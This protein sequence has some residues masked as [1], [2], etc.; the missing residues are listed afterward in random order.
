MPHFTLQRVGLN[1]YL[2]G[3][4]CYRISSPDSTI[5]RKNTPKLFRAS[6]EMNSAPCASPPCRQEY[7][8][9]HDFLDYYP[10]FGNWLG[11]PVNSAYRKD[12]LIA[13]GGFDTCLPAVADY[14]KEAL[15]ALDGG[16]LIEPRCLARFVLH[17]KRFFKG[18]NKRR[19][20]GLAEL[21]F[22]LHQVANFTKDR[23]LM[24]KKRNFRAGL[25][26]Q[27]KIDCW[28]PQKEKIKALLPWKK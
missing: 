5:C 9:P 10:H 6:F 21:W 1:H 2:Q 18:I 25:W 13:K 19:V 24:L 26:L 28:Y 15:C 27:A 16:V 20:N 4:S 22:I 17:D 11:G 7:L 14:K 8:S 3:T 23:K 12:F